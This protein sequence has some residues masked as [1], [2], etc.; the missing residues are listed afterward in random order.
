MQRLDAI[1][2][3]ESI[4]LYKA[5]KCGTERRE[6]RHWVTGA[7]EDTVA[8]ENSTLNSS[9]VS[10]QDEIHYENYVRQA[11]TVTLAHEQANDPTLI[12]YFDRVR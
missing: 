11:D 5:R 1:A 4:I 3:Y 10:I 8:S 2:A 9:T 6:W 7:T 12:E